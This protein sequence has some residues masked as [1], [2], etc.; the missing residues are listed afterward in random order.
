MSAGEQLSTHLPRRRLIAY[1]LILAAVTAIVIPI[2][3][4]AGSES[5][6]S[7]RSPAG[8]WCRRGPRASVRPPR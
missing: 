2:E 3:I 8:T 5:T 6:P 7:R 4:A 1:Y